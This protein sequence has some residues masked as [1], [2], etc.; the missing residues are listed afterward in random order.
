MEKAAGQEGRQLLLLLWP[1][2]DTSTSLVDQH[3]FLLSLFPALLCGVH[4]HGTHAALVLLPLLLATTLPGGLPFWTGFLLQTELFS[5][6]R[7]LTQGFLPNWRLF[8]TGLSLPPQP[9]RH[10]S[11]TL[12]WNSQLAPF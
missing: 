3:G 12:V 6:L 2:P 8:L 10:P 7:F 5:G 1:H 4:A 9:L 11:L